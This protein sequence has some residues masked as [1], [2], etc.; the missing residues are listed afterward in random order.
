MEL[1]NRGELLLDHAIVC[2]KDLDRWIAFYETALQPLGIVHA[3]DYDGKDGPKGHPDLK[4]FG[5]IIAGKASSWSPA[6]PSIC[7][8]NSSGRTSDA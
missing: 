1:S 7:A 6:V 2:V 3:I 8:R 5:R 4:R